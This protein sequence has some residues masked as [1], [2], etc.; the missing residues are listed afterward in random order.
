MSKNLNPHPQA[1][2][3]EAVENKLIEQHAVAVFINK[4]NTERHSL[5]AQIEAQSATLT[6]YRKSRITEAD[7][8][9]AQNR[10]GTI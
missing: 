7:V 8:R 9:R 3:L 1:A 2:D 10:R 5:C 4:K 6:A